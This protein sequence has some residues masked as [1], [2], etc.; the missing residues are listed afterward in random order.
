MNSLFS[1]LAISLVVSVSEAC[2]GPPPPTP[3]TTRAPTTTKTTP[4]TT[5]GTT[6]GKY[7]CP[8]GGPTDKGTTCVGSDNVIKIEASTDPEDCNKKCEAEAK[9]KFWTFVPTRKLCFLLSSCVKAAQE[10]VI[11]GEKGCKVPSKSFTLFNLIDAGI[12][13]CKVTWEPKDIC[14]EQQANGDGKIAALGKFAFTY[15]DA[16]PSLACTEIKT[17]ACK[18]DNAGTVKDCTLNPADAIK[19]K[20]VTNLYVKKKLPD[21]TDCEI[22]KS[23]KNLLG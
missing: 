7:D 16:P 3:T 21:G 18:W 12:T 4:T 13:E 10:G 5:S 23:P 15:F 8:I 1:V 20:D 17:V 14:P 6:T 19:V 2:W 11:S 9:C 22:S